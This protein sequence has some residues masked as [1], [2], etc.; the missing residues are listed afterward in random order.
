MR[1]ETTP[2]G[3]EVPQ[4]DVD[5]ILDDFQAASDGEGAAE[6]LPPLCRALAVILEGYPHA[7][8]LSPEARHAF[9]A[10]LF[11][12][13]AAAKAV[14]QPHYFDE[15]GRHGFVA[16]FGLLNRW[17]EAPGSNARAVA[18]PEEPKVVLI[19]R[20]V[21]NDLDTFCAAEALARLG[22]AIRPEDILLTGGL[23]RP[24]ATPAARMN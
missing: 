22:L 7:T 24:R 21:V 1:G 2:A 3:G 13:E 14:L 18:C 8:Q 6:V 17:A 19:L 10:A 15:R 23:S 11:R 20:I 16:A 5:A 4:G 9:G 12:A